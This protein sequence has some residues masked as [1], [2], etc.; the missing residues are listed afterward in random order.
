M[1][2]PKQMKKNFHRIPGSTEDSQRGR[3]RCTNRTMNMHTRVSEARV[4]LR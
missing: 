1:A 3:S 4:R 2:R